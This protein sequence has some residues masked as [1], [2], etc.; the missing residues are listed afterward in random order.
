MPIAKAIVPSQQSSVVS[1]DYPPSQSLSPPRQSHG[2]PSFVGDRSALKHGEISDDCKEDDPLKAYHREKLEHQRRKRRIRS[3]PDSWHGF[4]AWLNVNCT[5]LV[6]NHTFQ[7][8]ILMCICIN[9]LM[10]GMVTFPI[11][12]DDPALSAIFDTADMVFLVIFTVD[13]ALQLFSRGAKYFRDGWPLFDLV[14]VL[15]SWMSISITGLYAFRVFR[16]FRLI[17]RVEMMRNV[18]VVL[19]HVV[20]ALSGI[21][22]LLMLVMYI[23]AVLCT[24][25]FKDYYPDITS[26]DYFG[27]LELSFFTLFQFICM[28]SSVW[29]SI[30]IVLLI[31]T[32]FLHFV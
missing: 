32:H 15:I 26:G 7:I 3:A 12:K 21:C 24:D 5:D 11:I 4:V 1:D 13:I 16:A 23:Y 18:V 19:F 20:P 17:T 10:L 6:E 25:L 29:K 28:V 9:S 30:T 2:V 8:F 22:I 31:T 14:V 27:G